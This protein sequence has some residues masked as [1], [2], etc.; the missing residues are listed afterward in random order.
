M[1]VDLEEPAS[2]AEMI[3][4]D[5]SAATTDTETT[6][7]STVETDETTTSEEAT[8]KEGEAE[9]EQF[10]ENPILDY[11]KSQFPDDPSIAKYATDDAFLKGYQNAQKLVGQR[12]VAVETIRYLEN[13]GV[14]SRELSEWLQ[15]RKQAQATKQNTKQPDP[16]TD[17]N[18][19]DPD[20]VVENENGE[21]MATAKNPLPPA[22]LAARAKK[23]RSEMIAR[24]RN[25]KLI[26][27]EVMKELLPEIDRRIQESQALTQKQVQAYQAQREEDQIQADFID[28]HAAVLFVD[29]KPN[30]DF[31]NWTPIAYQVTAKAKKLNT[32]EYGSLGERLEEALK[33][34]A[35]ETTPKPNTRSL[36]ASAKHQV[37]PAPPVKNKMN[38]DE[39]EEA[40][41]DASVAEMMAA[42][43]E[44]V[45]K[46]FSGK[47]PNRARAKKK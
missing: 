5:V 41:P 26:T 27:N 40:W 34:A 29:G 14:T 44:G 7:T 43:P 25:P 22:E 13:E 10:S 15:W 39:F 35:A 30:A 6:S 46:A 28:R 11:Y 3:S 12:E 47:V 42:F 4:Q 1:S 33:W 36:P 32:Q 2:L 16:I 24:I 19:F 8:P 21:W 45:D 31:S 37:A 38:I 9:P 20:W 23:Y 17:P 18:Y